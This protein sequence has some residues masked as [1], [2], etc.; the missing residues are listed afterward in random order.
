MF[1]V[2]DRVKVKDTATWFQGRRGYVTDDWQKRFPSG[3]PCVMVRIDGENQHG[4][5]F[6]P[7]ELELV[8]TATDI[9]LSDAIDNGW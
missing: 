4:K 1:N 5:A 8:M 6:S 7:D 3:S 9:A 2:G